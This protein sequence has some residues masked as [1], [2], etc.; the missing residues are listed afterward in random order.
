MKPGLIPF[1]PAPDEAIHVGVMRL[2]LEVPGSR[3]LKDRRHGVR[4]VKDRL[5]ARFGAAVAEVGH[6][7]NHQR[8]VLAVTIVGNDAVV[9]RSRL[10]QMR[11]DVNNHPD[12]VLLDAYTDVEV[13]GGGN[14]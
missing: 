3:S 9:V 11:A 1:L 7:E 12:V 2:S 5:A 10:D 6:L 4:S 14:G 13:W 8:C